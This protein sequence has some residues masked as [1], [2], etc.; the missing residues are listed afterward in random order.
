MKSNDRTLNVLLVDDN[1]DSCELFQMALEMSGHSV[2]AA[3]DGVAGYRAL[4]EGSFDVAVLD[5]GLPGMDGYE[6]ARQARVTLGDRTPMLIALTGYGQPSD[7]EAASGAG[8]AAHLLKPVE[9]TELLATIQRV[10]AV[11]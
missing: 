10:V 9:V 6:V 5:I 2:V 1:D 3:N 8:F 7:K 11:G 4:V